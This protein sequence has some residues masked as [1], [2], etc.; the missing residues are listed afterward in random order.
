ML[1]LSQNTQ[2]AFRKFRSKEEGSLTVEFMIVLP[3][4]VWGVLA[5]LV[6]WDGFQSATANQR[7]AYL[8][9]DL[10]SR[11]V[12]EIDADYLEGVS[13]VAR[14]LN[15]HDRS[16]QLRVTVVNRTLDDDDEPIHE[17][18][19]SY[20]TQK[21]KK[22]QNIEA[23]QQRLPMMA[24]GDQLIYVEAIREWA[25]RFAI[26]RLDPIRFEYVAVTMPR[27]APQIVLDTGDS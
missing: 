15:D 5:M 19:W 16:T 18:G 9:A 27:F 20:G 8:I 13:D 14:T 25:P 4:L 3:L 22:H 21:L 23:I 26:A 10:I 1:T 24:V 6:F 12:D 11:E 7:T 17:I 2:R